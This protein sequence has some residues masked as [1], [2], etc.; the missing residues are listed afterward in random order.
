M[1]MYLQGKMC[2]GFQIPGSLVADNAVVL[3]ANLNGDLA[4]AGAPRKRLTAAE[5]MA[6]TKER[7]HQTI[8][9]LLD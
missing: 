8:A 7:Y 1:M 6:R 4:P 3:P 2:G 9:Y 5:A